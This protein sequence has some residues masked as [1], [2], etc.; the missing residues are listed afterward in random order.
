[1]L[2]EV[3][4]AGFAR[5][6]VGGTDLIPDHMGD[7]RRPAIRHDHDLQAVGKGEMADLGRVGLG[8][9]GARQES[10]GRCK[11]CASDDSGDGAGFCR[12]EGHAGFLARVGAQTFDIWQ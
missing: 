11:G 9:T 10:D 12:W 7:H 8:R 2:E 4:D 6:F 3:G 1:M 5:R